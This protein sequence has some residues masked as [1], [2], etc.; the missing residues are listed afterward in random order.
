[1]PCPILVTGSNRSGSTWVGQ[2]LSQAPNVR[3][4]Y[5]PFNPVL[6]K[7]RFDFDLPRW[8]VHAEDWNEEALL[9]L[10]GRVLRPPLIDS[11]LGLSPL[12]ASRRAMRLLL[13]RY[14]PAA[15]SP[16][17]LLKDPVAIFSAAWLARQM[18]LRVVVLVRH[19]ASF[20]LSL[21]KDP[22]HIHSFD[23]VFKQQPKLLSSYPNEEQEL[24]EQV[25]RQQLAHGIGSDMI[26]EGSVFWRLFY[27]RVLTYQREFPKWL[28]V[29]YEGLAVDPINGFKS[30]CNQLGLPFGDAMQAEIRKTAMETKTEKQDLA[31]HVKSYDASS[32][33]DVWRRHFSRA[34]LLRI[35]KLTGTVGSLYYPEMANV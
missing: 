31:S 18:P 9:D 6:A 26:L 10:V 22:T 7:S 19:P 3:N 20:V 21:L 14:G 27:A 30:L 25:M 15:F 16:Q 33:V 5:E 4:I 12:A 17:I 35:S 28:I 34:D 8:F 24:V 13:E 23:I 32:N 2:V 11:K 29:P 1:M